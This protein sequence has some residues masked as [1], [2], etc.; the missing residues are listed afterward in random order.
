MAGR[1]VHADRGAGHRT[2]FVMQGGGEVVHLAGAADA[3][4][5]L[6]AR[7]LSGSQPPPR[8]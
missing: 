8:P 6:A 5:Y 7:G 3:Q 2:W 1:R 4:E